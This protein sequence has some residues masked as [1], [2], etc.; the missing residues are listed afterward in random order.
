MLNKVYVIFYFQ[1]F[2]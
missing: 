1:N 2:R